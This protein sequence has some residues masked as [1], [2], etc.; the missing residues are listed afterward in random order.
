M[1]INKKAF[2]LVEVLIAMSIFTL[3]AI[4]STNI[5]ANTITT[6]KKTSIQ[7][8]IYEDVRIIMQE[9]TKEIQNGTIDYEEYFSSS[10]IQ[11]T[12]TPKYYGI[13]YGV[14]ASR[15]YN[16]GKRADGIVDKNPQ[17][18]GYECSIFDANGNCTVIFTHS[19]DTNT[20]NFPYQGDPSES[21]A[22]CQNVDGIYCNEIVDNTVTVDQLYIIDSAGKEKTILAK[23][24]IK[25][26]DYALGLMKMTGYDLDQNSI[27]DVFSC[28]ED[29]N[30]EDDIT[31]IKNKI[32]YPFIQEAGGQNILREH[33]IRLASQTTLTQAFSVNT[34]HFIPI[35]PLRANIVDL[36]FIIR[37]LEDPF[38]AY[39][40]TEMQTVPSVTVIMEVGLSK[41]EEEKYPGEFE[42]FIVQSTIPVGTSQKINTYPPVKD[43]T[44]PT[45]PNNI[46]S[47]VYEVLNP[48]GLAN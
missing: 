31:K 23:Q 41:A 18:L 7:N 37:P 29:F 45:K 19:L 20:G 14:Y 22:F 9:I 39:N 21:N 11:E 43:N 1:K 33:N 10:V 5:L 17:D 2:T 24:L 8:A 35:S 48:V 27:M 25:G 46:N 26:D 42:N 36:K 32:K 40:E 3:A 47:W 4:I 30:C 44:R 28:K 15:F 13:N 34:S 16:P 12:T 6:Q 38:K